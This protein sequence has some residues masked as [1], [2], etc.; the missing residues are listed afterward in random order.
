MTA[1]TLEKENNYLLWIIHMILS[2]MTVLYTNH[3]NIQMY[4]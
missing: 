1:Y 2:K 3:K 4:K